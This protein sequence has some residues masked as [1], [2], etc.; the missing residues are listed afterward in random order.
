VTIVD[1]KV[2]SFNGSEYDFSAGQPEQNVGFTGL[3]AYF[4]DPAGHHTGPT[5][6]FATLL[7]VP[8][9]ATW[10]LLLS[11]LALLAMPRGRSLASAL[12][13]RA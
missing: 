13:T 5:D 3:S 8:E 9:P 7:M 1:G 11:G 2:T 6:G 4:H 12:R 10:L